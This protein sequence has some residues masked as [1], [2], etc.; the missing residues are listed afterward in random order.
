MTDIGCYFAMETIDDAYTDETVIPYV[1][2]I[3]NQ[4]SEPKAPKATQWLNIGQTMACGL[5]GVFDYT[6]YTYDFE[7]ANATSYELDV[8]GRIV[9]VDRSFESSFQLTP[10]QFGG[11]S[12]QFGGVPSQFGAA[13]GGLSQDV[14]NAVFKILIKSKIS[15]NNGAATLDDISTALQFIVNQ[16]TVRVIDNEDMTFSVSFG[17]ELTPLEREVLTQ[18]D[19]VPRPQGVEFLGFTEELSITQFGGGLG[20]GSTRAQFGF[21]FI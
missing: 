1:N 14:N 20:F 6:R 9:G 19:V 21:L 12:S 8:V 7:R 2:R 3:Y 15:K 17:S 16:N 4:Y 18:F 13:S 5:R 11:V 10:S